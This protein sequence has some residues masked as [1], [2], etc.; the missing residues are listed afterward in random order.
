VVLGK[1]LDGKYRIEKLLGQGGMGAVYAAEAIAAG[2]HVALGQRVAVKIIHNNLPDTKALIQRFEREARA[3][4]SVDTEHIARCLDAG[5]DPD[6]ERPYMVL[7]YLVGEDLQHLLRRI[8]PLP[9]EVALR[10]VGQAC[11]GLAKAHEATIIHRD[12]KPANLFLS[13]GDDGMRIVKILDFGVAKMKGDPSLEGSAGAL[14]R[15]GSILGSPLYM[16]PEQARS[17][18]NVDRRSD[19]WSIGVVLYQMLAGRTPFEHVSGLGDLILALCSDL[20]PPVQQ[21]APWVSPEVAAIIDHCLRIDLRERYQSANEL[22]EALK[23]LV[24]NGSFE[25]GDDMLV[26]L[27]DETHEYIAPT[28]FR[29]I[30]SN[31]RSGGRSVAPPPMGLAG[32][33]PLD[34]PAPVS[35]AR[36]SSSQPAVATTGT[37]LSTSN[38]GQQAPARPSRTVPMLLVAA[39]C[40]AGGAGA[41]WVFSKPSNAGQPVNAGA[42]SAS[43]A[44][45]NTP[46]VT[47]SATVSASASAAES[48]PP[49]ATAAPATA[50]PTASAPVETSAPKPVAGT[51]APR[52]KPTAAPSASASAGKSIRLDHTSFGDRK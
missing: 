38:G 50:A 29:G 15:T 4:S 52:P 18:K 13:K 37:G 39:A 3:A 35:P 24:P 17:V 7:E 23:P 45:A 40:V 48:A 6:G 26:P 44:P 42:V 34:T 20:P 33:I 36:P 9:P 21:F 46:T 5:T 8:G 25:L 11:L 32:T 47:P 27:D 2:P 16:S 31:S 10:I 43:P 12:I 19:L 22:V 49:P 41:A 28:Y 30:G 14:T 51:T 1:T